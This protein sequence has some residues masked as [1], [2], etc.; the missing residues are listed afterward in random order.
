[1]SSRASSKRK[2]KSRKSRISRKS[3]HTP[4][5]KSRKSRKS[6]ASKKVNQATEYALPKTMKIPSKKTK[7]VQRVKA[8]RADP[9]MSMS[10]LEFMAKSLGI[11]FGGL[12]KTQLAR[13]INNYF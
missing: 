12:N 3:K 7:S 6:R 2:P 9:N 5:P 4:K 11:P 8:S 10:D 13:K 1:M